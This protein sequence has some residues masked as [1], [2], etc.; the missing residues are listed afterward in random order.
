MV[1]E[2]KIYPTF[3]IRYRRH[4]V[5]QD[6]R[7][8]TV[9]EAAAI[10]K[11]TGMTVYRMIRAGHLHARRKTLF[12]RSPLVLKESEVLQLMAKLREGT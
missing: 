2:Y 5:N 6:E 1:N 3:R 4:I 11:V 8:V 12:P 7:E 9:T 10:L